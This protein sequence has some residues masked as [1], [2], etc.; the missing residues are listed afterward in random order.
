MFYLVLSLLPFETFHLI[1]WQSWINSVLSI[2]LQILAGTWFMPYWSDKLYG[3]RTE[4]LSTTVEGA[5]K[6][7]P[8]GTT[9]PTRT[10][11][12]IQIPNQA[13]AEPHLPNENIQHSS[14]I[15]FLWS[16]TDRPPSVS[17]DE[18]V[19]AIAEAWIQKKLEDTLVLIPFFSSFS[20]L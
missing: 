12:T 10:R 20:W 19:T 18:L 4:D 13:G 15:I 14:P 1:M 6:W 5:P 9:T 11:V 7:I 17:A 3:S 2:V 8:K 16:I